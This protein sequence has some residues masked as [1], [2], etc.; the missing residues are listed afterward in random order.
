MNPRI[1]CILGLLLL[2][3]AGPALGQRIDTPYRFF[4][5]TQGI[6][7]TAAYISTDKGSIGLGPESG[8]AF[9][10]R[11]HI[12]LSGPFFVEAEALYFPTT[13]A[14]FD[15]VV[16]AADSAFQ[17][18]GE[19]DIG[20][21]VAHAS[22]RF[23]LTGQR[24]W[25]RILPFVLLGVGVAVEATDDEA[26]DADVPGEARFDFGTT[27]AGQVGAGIE[28][29]PAERLAIR[30]DGRTVL[31][32]L[33]TPQALLGRDIGRTVPTEEWTNNF[34]ASVGLSIHF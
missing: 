30:I 14:V 16:V 29:F 33:E 32:Q 10:G 19:A 17:Q 25:N 27:F 18:V 28:L 5:E 15:T 26:A 20:L 2:A 22:L 13:R 6:G 8:V 7:L 11:Y 24:T 23:H 4:E 31:W 12:R 3:G 1:G 9:G 21:A 34:T